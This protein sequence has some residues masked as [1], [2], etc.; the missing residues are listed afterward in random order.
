MNLFIKE[1]E[2]RRQAA[3]LDLAAGMGT[4]EVARDYGVSREAVR[5]WRKR[6]ETGELGAKKRPGPKPK[7][8]KSQVVRVAEVYCMMDKATYA[9]VARMIWEMF[10]VRYS[11]QHVRRMLV[12]LGLEVRLPRES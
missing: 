11:Q 5:M 3:A 9:Q 10:R 1:L 7:L 2:E 12:K 4:C 8:T 6:M